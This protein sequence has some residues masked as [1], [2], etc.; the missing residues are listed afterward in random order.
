[1]E[2]FAELEAAFSD[3]GMIFF[4]LGVEISEICLGFGGRTEFR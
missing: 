4:L 1:L 2:K 3:D